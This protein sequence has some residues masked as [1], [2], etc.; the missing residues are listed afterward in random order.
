MNFYLNLAYS[1]L[2]SLLDKPSIL[3][4]LNSKHECIRERLS[5]KSLKVNDKDGQV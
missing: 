4:K 3:Y 1:S 5:N 2:Q